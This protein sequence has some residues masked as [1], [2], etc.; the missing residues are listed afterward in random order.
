[1]QRKEKS[2]KLI[3]I[4]DY[5][6]GGI[7]SRTL[8]LLQASW[9]KRQAVKPGA[10]V[11]NQYSWSLLPNRTDSRSMSEIDAAPPAIRSLIP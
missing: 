7:T 5:S 9:E 11:A 1:M 2:E 4:G 3:R 8:F 10:T 6:G